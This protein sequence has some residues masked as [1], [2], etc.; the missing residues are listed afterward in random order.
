MHAMRERL[1]LLHLVSELTS[2]SWRLFP[3]F[4]LERWPQMGGVFGSEVAKTLLSPKVYALPMAQILQRTMVQGRNY[5][6]VVS[7]GDGQLMNN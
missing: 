2:A 1:K 3:D 7:E 4:D 5:G 6:P